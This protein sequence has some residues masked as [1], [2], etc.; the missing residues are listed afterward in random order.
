VNRCPGL[1]NALNGLGGGGQLDAKTGANSNSAL[2][3]CFSV[4][5][6]FAGFVKPKVLYKLIA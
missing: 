2:Y 1:F 4:V 5:A 6:F 3:A